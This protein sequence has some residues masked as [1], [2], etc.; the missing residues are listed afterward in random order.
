MATTENSRV[1][2]LQLPEFEPSL[3]RAELTSRVAVNCVKIKTHAQKKKK[4][5]KTKLQDVNF[6]LRAV[7]VRAERYFG[8]VTSYFHT[9]H[10]AGLRSLR[11]IAACP[12]RAFEQRCVPHPDFQARRRK[13]KGETEDQKQVVP[14]LPPFSPPTTAD[15]DESRGCT[16]SRCCPGERSA[17]VKVAALERKGELLMHSLLQLQHWNK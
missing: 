7:A 6:R 9:V 2:Y 4:T 14:S 16:H 10:S 3:C 1:E 5:I 12:V 17:D 8:S 11:V 13:N 15:A